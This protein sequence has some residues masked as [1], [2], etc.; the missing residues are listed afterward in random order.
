MAMMPAK[1]AL[2]SHAAVRTLPS[3]SKIIAVSANFIKSDRVMRVIITPEDSISSARLSVPSR[4]IFPSR[5][6][7]RRISTKNSRPKVI[8]S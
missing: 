5:P 2:V 1:M 8:T 6:C 3:K 4:L 7:G